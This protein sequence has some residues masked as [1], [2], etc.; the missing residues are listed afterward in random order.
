[1]TLE[2]RRPDEIDGP[3]IPETL[4]DIPLR[5]PPRTVPGRFQVG[6]AEHEVLPARDQGRCKVLHED[7]PV[8][9]RERMEKPRI[10]GRIE[11]P[12]ERVEGKSV[13]D[14]KIHTKPPCRSLLLCLPDRPGRRV[15]PPHLVPRLRKEEGVIP[16]PAPDV[17]DRPRNLT[18]PDQL[19]ERLPGPADVPRGSALVRRFKK[20]YATPSPAVM[21]F[22]LLHGDQPAMEPVKCSTI[23]PL[24]PVKKE[25]QL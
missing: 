22:L 18:G 9:I 11:C 16:G 19:D 5:D 20:L 6:K 14:T 8:R 1:M 12:P 3:A 10:R 13:H 24:V 23:Y 7:R 25:F 2:R 4:P 15:N 21:L 17:E